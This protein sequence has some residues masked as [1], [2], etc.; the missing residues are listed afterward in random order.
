MR[1]R[2][3]SAKAAFVIGGY[4]VSVVSGTIVE[5]AFGPGRGVIVSGMIALVVVLWLTRCFRGENESDAP[6]S[7]WR[8]SAH[9]TAGFVLAGWF[10]V[11][12]VVTGLSVAFDA[13]PGAGVSAVVSSVIAV[14]YLNSSVRLATAHV[15]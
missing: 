9:P 1:I 2:N 15:R 5:L 11:Q 12:G 13:P 7:W 6:R 8:M 4:L 14:G 3:G 10:L